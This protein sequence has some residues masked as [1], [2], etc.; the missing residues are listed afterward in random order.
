MRNLIGLL[1]LV[2]CG[3]VFAIVS[4]SSPDGDLPATTYFTQ[5]ANE[6]PE[7]LFTGETQ[8]M[9]YKLGFYPSL[10]NG[11][12]TKLYQTAIKKYQK[13]IDAKQTGI[14][15]VSQWYKLHAAYNNSTENIPMKE[16]H[17]VSY[18]FG[19]SED[20]NRVFAKGTWQFTETGVQ[21]IAPIQ[22]SDIR[23]DKTN[24]VC[25][26]ARALL[27][28]FTDEDLLD[29]ELIIWRVTKWDDS[30]IIAENDS[31]ECIAYTLYINLNTEVISQTRRGKNCYGTAAQPMTI[32][33]V[34]GSE[35]A[36]AF[37]QDNQVKYDTPTHTVPAIM[38]YKP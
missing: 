20:G 15:T 31:A 29:S 38:P 26:E 11:K 27:V 37:Y 25:A 8:F 3:S 4:P 1:G 36:N 32:K 17:P 30:E 34:D 21:M 23:C 12:N 9:L 13:T 19:V 6:Q 18:R 14:L 28:N 24:E 7:M 16:V 2:V 35:I 5:I 10:P 22:S 33:L